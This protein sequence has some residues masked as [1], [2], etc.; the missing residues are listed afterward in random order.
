M[1]KAAAETGSGYRGYRCIEC[2]HACSELYHNVCDGVVK[3]M[4]CVMINS[5]FISVVFC[6]NW[7]LLTGILTG[8][9]HLSVSPKLPLSSEVWVICVRCVCVQ[10]VWA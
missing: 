9:Y 6:G 5:V 1:M 4:H 7:I 10:C 3:L 2:G 8:I